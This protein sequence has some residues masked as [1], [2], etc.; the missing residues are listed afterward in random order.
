[1]QPTSS[2]ITAVWLWLVAALLIAM[3]LVGG[4]TRL[5]D[6][7]LSITEWRPVTGAIPPLNAGDWDKAFAAYR[8]TA[9]FQQVNADMSLAQFKT[10]YWWEWGHRLLGRI[11]G[12]AFLLPFLALLATRRLPR[13][14]I[15][16][17][18]GLFVLGGLQG[19]VGWWMVSSGLVD[20]VDVLPE[21]LTAHLGLALLLF[22]ALIWAALEAGS[23]PAAG[24]STWRSRAW[25]L[26]VLALA[27][28]QCLLG[29][30][31]AGNDAGRIH[32]DWPTMSGALIP[33][34]YAR[35][36]LWA[37][38]AHSAAAVQL[39]HR[40]GAYLL[41]VVV[42]LWVGRSLVQRRTDLRQALMVTAAVSAQATLG[43]LTLMRGA[44]ADLSLA[45]QAGALV[46][47][48]AAVWAAWRSGRPAQTASLNRLQGPVT[49]RVMPGA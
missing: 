38:L 13:R 9:E 22:C 20:R 30:L 3:V 42:L 35:S 6:S 2:R 21:R 37:T 26:S 33:A 17:C 19:A 43:V 4:A 25:P 40:L 24:R 16:P 28:G 8:A 14:L 32:T 23:A 12:A 27:F 49:A 47:L 7:G 18:V 41:T 11:I 34:D 10:I 1:M 46:V 5:T 29:G 44:P 31:V 39:H 36:D 48:A 15:W 45:H